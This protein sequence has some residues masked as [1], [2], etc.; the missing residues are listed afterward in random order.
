LDF[1][2][3]VFLHAQTLGAVAD[4][5]DTEGNPVDEV[6]GFNAALTPSKKK[7]KQPKKSK[8]KLSPAMI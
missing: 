3:Y 4:T 6:T 7:T 1:P 5:A 2:S 8:D